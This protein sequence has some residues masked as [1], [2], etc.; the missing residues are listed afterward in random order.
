MRVIGL[1]CSDCMHYGRMNAPKDFV[2]SVL[3]RTGHPQVHVP[4]SRHLGR[5]GAR[6]LARRR[7]MDVGAGLLE[8]LQLKA[9]GT[10][11]EF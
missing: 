5:E 7:A 9:D 10:M 4:R 1:L 6:V 3:N 11:A 2:L 8:N